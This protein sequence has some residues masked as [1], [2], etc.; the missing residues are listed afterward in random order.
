MPIQLITSE[1]S[2]LRIKDNAVTYSVNPS[3]WLLQNLGKLP[4]HQREV[5]RE[6]PTALGKELIRQSGS[7]HS[8]TY[9]HF[10]H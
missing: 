7:I 6:K 9:F 2:A 5:I 8:S 1:Y 4:D 10:T 3:N